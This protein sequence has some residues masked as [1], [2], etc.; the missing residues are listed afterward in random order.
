MIWAL[1]RALIHQLAPM[2]TCLLIAATGLSKVAVVAGF[3]LLVVGLGLYV[4]TK[5]TLDNAQETRCLVISQSV[6]S[7]ACR[8]RTTACTSCW[9]AEFKVSYISTEGINITTVYRADNRSCSQTNVQAY[10]DE[11][12]ARVA[13]GPPLDTCWYDRTSPSTIYWELPKD[14]NSYLGLLIAGSFKFRF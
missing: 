14:L 4:P 8:R 5:A 2:G 12:A 1:K 3:A 6:V 9:A 11:F 7:T 13:S 10:A